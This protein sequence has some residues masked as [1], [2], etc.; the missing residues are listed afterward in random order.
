[1]IAVAGPDRPTLD[2][3]RTMD[4]PGGSVAISREV[5]ADL[6][7]PVSAYLKVRAGGPSF[8]LESAEGGERIGRY[9]FIGA[10]PRRILRVKGGQQW[11]DGRSPS[12][13]SDPLHAVKAIVDAYGTTGLGAA[14]FEGG[15]LGYLSYEAVRSFER[16]PAAARDP[17]QL[18]DAAFFD[19]DTVLIFDHIGRRARIVSHAW[20]DR[21]LDQAYAEAVERI[22]ALAGRL[23]SPVP[24][25]PPP[26][27]A[28]SELGSNMERERYEG[29]VERG[30]EHIAAG[31]ILQVVLAQRLSI[32]LPGDPFGLYR[33]LRIVSPAPYMYYLDFGD[34]QI[35][36]ASP[37]LL[38]QIKSGIVSA[39]PIAGTR[40]RGASSEEDDALAVD[41]L[42]DEKERAEHLMLVDLA[43]N[44]V[45]RVSRPGTVRVKNFMQVERFSHVMHLVSDVEGEL[46]PECSLYDALRAA[47]PAG[48]VSGAPKIRAM[49]IIADQETDQRG[50][51]A[52]C[53]GFINPSG[54]LEMAITIRT[55]VVKDAILHI[56]VGAGIV[57]DSVPAN[58]WV[59]TM[60]KARA[61]LEAAGVRR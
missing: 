56:E 47:F 3:L 29:I 33:R 9:S 57:A 30:K 31:D 49:Q 2:Q 14:P 22:D 41:L 52:G 45:G 8:L 17:L 61:L 21:P 26:P 44:D 39:R 24:H 19:V 58:E 59:E 10:A 55:G 42:A 28:G 37:E 27:E 18:P 54:D 60:N 12:P 53:V 46:R 15:A 20:L 51:Y 1:M 13:C 5:L 25:A 16:L 38:V 50:P 40:P 4:L 6:D 7:T 48:T 11:F 43:R 35:V 23:A 34:H 32:P 36:G